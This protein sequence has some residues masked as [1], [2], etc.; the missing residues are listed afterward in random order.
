MTYPYCINSAFGENEIHEE[1]TA[2]IVRKALGDATTTA[3]VDQHY[4]DKLCEKV[5]E[6][7]KI[8][9]VAERKRKLS[10]I[11]IEKEVIQEGATFK[12]AHLIQAIGEEA[13]KRL[14]NLHK[15][16]PTMPMLEE[17][18]LSNLIE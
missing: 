1:G 15:K 11:L 3:S 4:F 6:K 16:E 2:Q 8:L 18:L 9:S 17:A 5:N 10:A 14:K 12:K 7:E 13:V